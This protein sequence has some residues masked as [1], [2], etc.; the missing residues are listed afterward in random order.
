M[1]DRTFYLGRIYDPKKQKITEASVQYDPADLVTHG[2]VVGMTGSGK[3]GLCIDILEE[4]ALLGIPAIAIDPKGDL[5]NLVLH[6][7]DLA[8][9]D[10]RPWIDPEIARREGKTIDQA[11]Q[12]T[13]QS[14]R[15][16]LQDWGIQ[17]ER[18]KK[19]ASAV[20]YTI[21]TPGSDSGISVNVLSS[22]EPP[23]LDW[24]SNREVIREKIT[25]T[26]TALLGLIGYTGIDPIRS[27][28]HILLANLLENSWSKGK[29]IDLQ[30][31][32]LQTQSPP[33]DKL[34]AFDVETFFP[35]K[36][37]REL[38]V[39][40]NNFLAAPGFEVWRTGESMDVQKLLFN[41]DGN[42]RHSIFYL[43]HLSDQEKMFFVTLL[44]A[45]IETWMRTQ[46]GVTSLRAIMYMDEIYGYLPP[47]AVPPSKGPLLR[48]LKQARAF[49]LGLLL[50]TQNPVDV[51]YKGLSNMGTW[52]IGKLQTDQDKQRLLDGLEGAAGEVSRSVL[53][54]LISSLGKRVFVLHNVHEKGPVVFY[55]RWTMN[56]LAGPLTREQ[57]PELNKLAHADQRVERAAGQKKDRMAA[58]GGS[59]GTAVLEL[60]KSLN[61]TAT[62]PS[63]PGG[64]R[65]YFLAQNLSL[66]EAFSASQKAMIPG[67][68]IQGV[69]YK[70]GLTALAQVRLLD[71][72]LGVDTE[73]K[74]AILDPNP[75]KRGVIRW[76]QFGFN[77]DAIENA[78]AGPV[79]PASFTQLGQPLND[80]RAMAAIQKDFSDWVYRNTSVAAR[81]NQALKVYAGPDVSQGEFIKNCA[82]AANK[83]SEAE[84]AKVNAQL[85]RQ[86]STLESKLNREE[87]ELKEDESDLQHRKWE[88]LGTA[89]ENVIS[90]FGGRRSSRRISSS[91]S[92]R[93]LTENAKSDV[94][95]SV[96]TISEVKR[97]LEELKIKRDN[98][99]REIKERWGSLVNEIT[100][101]YI[102]PK[103]TDIYISVFGVAWMPFYIVKAGSE[104][105]ELPAFKP[106]P[107]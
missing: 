14:W 90:L 49:G 57:I 59:V 13:S 97:Q 26:V 31:L 83:G 69:V 50:A 12:E 22:L 104:L 8:P 41:K 34:G 44:L 94:E 54:R 87:R 95:E 43:A 52:F 42:P 5:T 75:D 24:N 93:R 15:K 4:A 65:E 84:I 21:Y 105:I 9:T 47:V 10:F 61:A 37:R 99:S 45:S 30:E 53:D 68:A 18:L 80:S 81:A 89:A 3:T 25:G 40:L 7:P 32:I 71:R 35:T 106:G 86:I 39:A 73:M 70:P 85:D 78:E 100:E 48:M 72:K 91:L 27:R 98:T 63:V 76:E 17:E 74:R 101:T 55:T 6:F 82:E 51:D 92:K 29:E 2:F 11:A 88:E 60:G 96:G 62:K 79:D 77:S 102:N 20:E 67:A 64:T 33:I 107:D 46:T 58:T 28:E 19:L 38:A 36:E 1:A 16:G 66:P 103:K 23:A 56:F